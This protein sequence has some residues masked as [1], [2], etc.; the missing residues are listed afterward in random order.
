M[1]SIDVNA[2]QD[3]LNDQNSSPG[4]RLRYPFEN[5]DEYKAKVVFSLVETVTTGELAGGIFS[6]RIRAAQDKKRGLLEEYEAIKADL[7]TDDTS[8]NQYR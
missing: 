3:Q 7:D 6:E 8:S 5:E 1:A 4:N 2:T